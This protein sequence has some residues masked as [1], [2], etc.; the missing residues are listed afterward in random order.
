MA[1]LETYTPSSITMLA[2]FD[3]VDMLAMTLFSA[4]LLYYYRE[5]KRNKLEAN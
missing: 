3:I 1:L 2:T 5:A 4:D